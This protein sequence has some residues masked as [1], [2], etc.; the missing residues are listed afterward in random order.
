M[1]VEVHR[2][3]ITGSESLAVDWYPAGAQADCAVYVH[4]LGSHRRGEKVRHFAT[5]FNAAGWAFAAFDFRGHGDSDGNV[6][7]LTMTRLLA[8]LGVVLDWLRMQG[9]AAR[10]A[11]IGASMGAAVAAW[12]SMLH[13]G[14]VGPLVMIAPSLAFPGGLLTELD[15]AALMQWQR[16]GRRRFRSD[17]IDLE[18]GCEL[19]LDAV[20]YDPGRLRED[21][22]T[23]VLIV[24]GMRDEA[25]DYR[26]SVDFAA[27]SCSSS[28][29]VLLLGNGDHRLTDRRELLFGTIWSW[30]GE[31][32]NRG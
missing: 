11:L 13:A 14:A 7:D 10:P 12:Y 32:A 4:G 25:I 1:T 27:R 3:V 8:D 17:W 2:I 28:V 9:V 24:H 26:R 22:V 15:P 20:D 29:D 16:T 18:I 23:P 30:L 5:R 21:L 31:Q 6:V 19:A